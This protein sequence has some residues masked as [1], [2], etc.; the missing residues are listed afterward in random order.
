MNATG[1]PGVTLKPA[2]PK[3]HSVKLRLDTQLLVYT[4]AQKTVSMFCTFSL[5]A[6]LH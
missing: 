6:I 2:A 3:G 4:V 1:R 5:S